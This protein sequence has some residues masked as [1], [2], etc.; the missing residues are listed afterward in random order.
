MQDDAPKRGG[1]LAG[2]RVIELAHIMAGPV[3]GLMLADMGAEVIKVEKLPAATTPAARSRP[4]LEGESAAYLMMNRGKRGIALDLKAP[5]R[6]AVLRR[7]LGGADVLIE[8]YRRRHDG[9]PR[10]RLRQPHGRVP[11]PD[12]LLALGLRPH[13]PLRRPRRLRPRR[14]G[15]ERA[16]EHHRR[17]ARPAA[18][19]VRAAASPTSPP[20]S[21]RP[22]ACS[23]PTRTGSGPARARS[24]TPRCSRPASPTPTGS[25]RSA[26]R[27]ACRPGR[28]A[29]PTRSTRP[30]RPSRPPTA[31][32]PSAPPTRRTGC[33]SSRSLGAEDL[34]E[35]S[36]LRQNR[37][38]MANRAALAAALAPHFRGAA[39]A[40]WLARLEAGGVPAGPVLDVAAMH[41]DPQ[42]L[43]REMVVEVDHTRIGPMRDA[44]PAGQVLAD[45]RPGPRA[46]AAPRRAHPGDPA[47]GRLRGGRDRRPDRAR[48]RPRDPGVIGLR[49]SPPSPRV[50]MRAAQREILR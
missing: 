27:P 21:W 28:W 44:R 45:A 16:D 13:R 25:R 31:G 19:E 35:R 39:S 49:R 36:P 10:P 20:A 29:P 3:C 47:R 7:L 22:W 12:L 1:P 38:R 9:A 43:A 33:G 8:N 15:H 40:E 6:Q 30:T 4:A 48:R 46:G 18:D 32:S 26:W 24:S 42:T 5:E 23:P 37:D 41:A 50:S 2:V 17:G 14:A 34:A 11:G